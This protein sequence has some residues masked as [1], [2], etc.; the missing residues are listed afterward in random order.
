M[1]PMKPFLIP[2]VGSAL[3]VSAAEWS[4]HGFDRIELTNRYYSEGINAADIDADGQMDVI[5][6][7]FWFSGPDFKTKKLIYQAAPQNRDGYA[8]NFFSWPYDFNGDGLVDV[9]T[10][11]FPGKPAHVHQNPGKEGHEAPWPRHQ[12]FDWVSNESPHFTNLVGDETPELVCTR[13]GHFGWVEINPAN[14]WAA[15]N[16]YPISERMAPERFGHGLGVGDVNGDGRLDVLMKDGWFE[17]PEDLTQG[18]WKLHE[19]VFAQ[20]GGAEMFAYDVDGDGDSDVITSLA[21]HEYGLAWHEQTPQGFTEHLIM[22]DRPG[23]NRYGVYFSELHS[24]QLVDIDGD[25]LKDIVTGKTYWSHHKKSHG[26]DDGAV[27]YW[28]KLVRGEDGVDWIPMKAD[29]DAG[30]GRQL[31]VKD[32]NGDGLPDILAGGMKG[33]NVLLHRAQKVSQT[34]WQG[35]QPKPLETDAEPLVVGKPA[36]IDETSGLV[37]MALEGESLAA[38]ATVTGGAVK[39]QSMKNFTGARWSGGAQL[40]WSGGKVEDSLQME[41]QVP[42]AASYALEVVFTRAPDFA[43]VQLAIDGENLGS[44]IDLYQFAKVTTTGV[45]EH[46]LGKLSAGTHR[47]TLRIVGTNPHAVQSRCV[48][49]DFIRLVK[50]D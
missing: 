47:L 37:P 39:T 29:G 7:P 24:V 12:V 9:L 22:G 30:I 16:F 43:V 44:P 32:V 49:L 42:E 34:D 27:V 45:L 31:V 25:G 15:W 3:T 18:H 38:S 36:P 33:A 35:S 26:W 6:G 4:M 28:F 17:Q 13:D 1:T 2:L 5:H 8:N 19:V 23:L 21:A 20:R 40:F 14:P 50:Q 46:E 41:L 10:V 48:G 11:G